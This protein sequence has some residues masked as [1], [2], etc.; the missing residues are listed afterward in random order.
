MKRRSFFG[1]LLGAAAAPAAAIAATPEPS[2][3][4]DFVQPICPRCCNMQ[5]IPSRY[6]FETQA[7]WLAAITT[8][9]TITCGN[10]HCRHVMTVTFARKA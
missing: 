6:Q 10:D 4:L 9:Q 1:A 7:Q 8:P 2:H 3:A 5:A